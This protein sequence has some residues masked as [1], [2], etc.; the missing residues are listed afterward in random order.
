[1][2]LNVCATCTSTAAAVIAWIPSLDTVQY[3]AA[4]IAIVSGVLSVWGWWKKRRT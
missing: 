2:N 4:I 1:M 3:F